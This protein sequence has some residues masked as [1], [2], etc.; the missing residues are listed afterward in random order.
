MEIRDLRALLAVV[1]SGSFTTAARE[2]GYTQPAISQQV[3]ALELE[4]GQ[5]LVQRRPVRATPAGERLAEHAARILLRLDVARSELTSLGEAPAEVRVG[6]CPLA[7]PDLLAAALRDLRA[8]H[9]LLR[10][11]VRP[12]SPG[13]AVADVATGAVDAALADGITAPNEPLNL[14]DA[15]LLSS[16]AMAETPLV[17]ALA[18][19]HPL[20]G[21][22]GV[23]LDML[24]DAPWVAAPVLAGRGPVVPAPHAVYDGDD[25]PTLL[26]LVAAGLGAALLPA[27]AGPF[28]E[29]VAAVP[30]RSPRLVHRTELLALRTASARQRLVIDGLAAQAQ[31]F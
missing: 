7:A 30:L 16:T 6:V 14:A 5:P 8:L 20:R 10:V 19:D 22:P 28:P 12:V 31:A 29:G 18:T 23:D 27:S 1:R 4:L 24:A 2:L 25:L 17:V 26:A 3:A 11:K 21:R 15:G 13:S 9:P